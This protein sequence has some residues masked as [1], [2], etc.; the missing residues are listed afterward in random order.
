MTGLDKIVGE[1]R[2]TLGGGLG[3]MVVV[4]WR[5]CVVLCSVGFSRRGSG[6]QPRGFASEA[7]TA[8]MPC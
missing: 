7:Q 6:W 1:W 3:A 8:K 5:H 2:S 4:L